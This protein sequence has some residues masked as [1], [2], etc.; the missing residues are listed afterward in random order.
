MSEPK[1][2]E[3]TD[4]VAFEEQQIWFDQFKSADVDGLKFNHFTQFLSA[5]VYCYFSKFSHST[6]STAKHN[7]VKVEDSFHNGPLKTTQD[8]STNGQQ[9]LLDNGS[10]GSC[11]QFTRR[12]EMQLFKVFDVN[13][14]HVIDRNEF[15]LMCS[16]W[17]DT[18]YNPICALV[19][20]DVQ[21]DFID[22]SLALI[23]GPAGQDG[24]QVVPVINNLIEEWQHW[25]RKSTPTI[26]YTQDWHPPDHVSFYQNLHMR[27]YTI[28]HS[29]Q[30]DKASTRVTS[31]NLRHAAE[32][33]SANCVGGGD[34]DRRQEAPTG[35]PINSA[36]ISNENNNNNSNRF[37][38]KK[39]LTDANLFDTVLFEDGRVEQ[40]LWPTH[41][42]QNSWGAQLHPKLKLIPDAIRVQK[43]TLSHVDAYSAFWDNMHM[44][45]TGLR[46]ELLSKRAT[47]LFFCGLALDFC[48][49]SSALDAAKAGFVTFVIEDACRGIDEREIARRKR[50]LLDN[51]VFI[52]KSDSV[53]DFL[54]L[55]QQP[56]VQ[57]NNLDRTFIMTIALRRALVL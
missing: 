17:L 37:K 8:E 35:A 38:F 29:D 16:K 20:V 43:G 30:G 52:M 18:V 50:E 26:V 21:N 13:N 27:K 34:D 51:G 14:D 45:E 5:T 12:Q 3:L 41:C 57:V 46:Q 53:V 22:G 47:H 54:M 39:F 4:W 2:P 1:S 28:K 55:Q 25:C 56:E 6:Q 33:S 23:N 15:G 40:K 7:L 11:C 44:N 31:D 36:D 19:I 32:E 48:V 10:G 49:A 42:V 9:K 24:A